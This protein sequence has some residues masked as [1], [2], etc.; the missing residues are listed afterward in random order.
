MKQFYY[1]FCVLIA[2]MLGEVIAQPFNNS[3]S[4]ILLD[5]ETKEP[6]PSVNI[7]IS[8]TTWG[9]SSNSNGSFKI[10]SII[11]G[12]HEIVFSMIGYETHSQFCKITDSSKIFIRIEMVPKVYEIKEVSVTAE[13]PEQWFDDLEEFKDEF[14][15]YSPYSYECKIVNEYDINFTHPEEEVLVAESYNL[16][17]VINYT[18]GYNVKCQIKRFEY[19]RAQ[20][21]LWYSYRL[22]FTE[23]DTNDLD[24]KK[25]WERN[26]K[27]RYKESLAFF[28]KTLFEGTFRDKGFDI[29]LVYKPGNIGLYISS[30]SDLIIKDSLAETCKL[31]FTEFLEVYNFY[32]DFEDLRTSWLK[33]NYPSITI[34]KYGYPLEDRATTIYGYWAKLGVASFLPK[35]YGFEESTLSVK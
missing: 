3:I 32:V 13:R 31:N 9:T 23:L 15:G 1:I 21:A 18:L 10:S 34:D 22:F 5:K 4:G 17:E 7:Y 20:K 27:C 26:R 28:L 2:A 12:N 24:V 8:N 35:Y 30:S 6:L 14:L 29:S 19:N 25:E 11:P 33:L 16:I